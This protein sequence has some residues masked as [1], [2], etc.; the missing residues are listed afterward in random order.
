LKLIAIGLIRV[1]CPG[2]ADR[3]LPYQLWHT[4]RLGFL[5]NQ[6]L[7]RAHLLKAAMGG[8]GNTSQ[9]L[10]RERANEWLALYGPD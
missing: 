1:I 4:S 10:Q 5:T 3:T 9:W 7:R 2:V 6:A 8:A